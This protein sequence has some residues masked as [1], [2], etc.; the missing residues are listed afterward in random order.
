MENVVRTVHVWI[1]KSKNNIRKRHEDADFTVATKG[2]LKNI[3][4]VYGNKTVFAVSI[5]DKS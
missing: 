1:R 5:D 2:Y 3:A 4:S